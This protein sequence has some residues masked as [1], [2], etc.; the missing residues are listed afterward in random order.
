MMVP[1]WPKHVVKE[2][3]FLLCWRFLAN[4]LYI[5]NTQQDAHYE[6]NRRL[7]VH[8][9]QYPCPW[10]SHCYY[11]IC[12]LLWQQFFF[13]SYSKPS[14]NDMGKNITT[15]HYTVLRSLFI[16]IISPRNVS[17]IQVVTDTCAVFSYWIFMVLKC[18]WLAHYWMHTVSTCSNIKFCK[19]IPVL[20]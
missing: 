16:I 2:N 9:K 5:C 15:N 20:N 18:N 8:L 3:T 1:M 13:S 7:I 11:E 10:W 12:D 4:Y 17:S 14:H 6:D 19:V